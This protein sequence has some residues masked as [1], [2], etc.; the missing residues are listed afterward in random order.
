M[1][2]RSLFFVLLGILFI[3]LTGCSSQSTEEQIHNHLEEAVALEEEFENQ[4]SVITDLESQEQEIYSQII[5]LG[6]DDIEQIKE[7]SS[8][9]LSII[10]E[11]EEKIELEKESIESSQKEF[12]NI[13]D[14]I[15]KIEDADLKEK[16]EKMYEVMDNRYSVYAELNEAYLTSLEKER[17]LYTMLEQEDLEQKELTNHINSI[18]ETYEQVLD[19]NEQFNNYTVEYNALKKEFYEA[20]ELDIASES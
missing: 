16:A 4:Q 7:L 15:S 14:L 13:D 5:D 10:D 20:A 1:R 18:N 8:E 17:K 19:L 9:A 12:S 6:M 3:V 11:R 2:V